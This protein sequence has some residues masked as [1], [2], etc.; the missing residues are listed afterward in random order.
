MTQYQRGRAFEWQLRD[1]LRADGYQVYRCAGSRSPVDLL[2]LKPNQIV[3]VQA[4]R[5]GRISPAD[6]ATL[7]D[8]AVEIGALAIVAAREPRRPIRYRRLTGAGP[9]DWTEWH[10]DEVVDGALP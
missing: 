3:Y 6:R 4:K 8:A 7:L 2:A 5:D 1:A 9:K 10:P